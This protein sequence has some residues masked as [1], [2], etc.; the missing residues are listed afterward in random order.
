[1]EMDTATFLR[2]FKRF[3]SRRGVPIKILSDN[4]KTFKAADKWLKDVAE[5]SDTKDHMLQ[6]RAV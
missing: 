2:C 1:M 6:N 3:T 4:A 5:H